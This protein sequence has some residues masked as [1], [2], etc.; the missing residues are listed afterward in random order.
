MA[1][2][3]EFTRRNYNIVNADLPDTFDETT[4]AVLRD[5]NKILLV[6]TPELPALRLAHLKGSA[7]AKAGAFR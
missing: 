7:A 3:I 2:L 4:L 6:T 1:Q 5:A